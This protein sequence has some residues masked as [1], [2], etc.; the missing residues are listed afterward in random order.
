MKVLFLKPPTPFYLAYSKGDEVVLQDELALQL[1]EGGFAS[2]LDVEAKP[3][4]DKPKKGKATA[5]ATSDSATQLP[6]PKS[7]PPK[8]KP[9]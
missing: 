5:A 2:V 4:A 7:K 9:E 8:E 3:T 6:D 1:V